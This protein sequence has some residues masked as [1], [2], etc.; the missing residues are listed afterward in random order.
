MFGIDS[1]RTD[2]G[3]IMQRAPPTYARNL[4]SSAISVE[5]VDFHDV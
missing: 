3:V 4:T 1:N 2:V 5:R